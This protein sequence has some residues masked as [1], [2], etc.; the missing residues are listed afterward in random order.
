MIEL[1]VQELQILLYTVPHF[2]RSEYYFRLTN[3]VIEREKQRIKGLANL[4]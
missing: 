2:Q 1:T 4:A 3:R